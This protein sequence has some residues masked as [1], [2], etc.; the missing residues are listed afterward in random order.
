VGATVCADNVSVTD[1]LITVLLD[2]GA[3]F[4]GNERFLE[5]EVRTDT[6]LDCT[7]SAGFVVLS[8]RQALR[9]APHA[10]YALNADQLDGLNSTAFLQSI[11]VPLT[12]S[13]TSATHIIRGENASTAP[14]ASGVFG[15]STAASGITFG[16]Y[17]QTN[18]TLGLGVFGHA[19]AS[20]GLTFGGQFA[21]DS[22]SGRGVHGIAL[23]NTGNTTGVH[24]Q[25]SST[26]G[27]AVF[28]EAT[29]PSG[30]TYG[31]RFESASTAGT[32]VFGSGGLHGGW[33]E[34]NSAVGSA[35]LA[36]ATSSN[37][38]GI[39]VSGFS[40]GDEGYGVYGSGRFG[41]FGESDF[42]NGVGVYGYANAATG[43]TFG[44]RFETESTAG[45]AVYGFANAASG[46][47]YGGYLQTS[48]PDG[49][50]VFAAAVANSGA[51]YGGYF[52]TASAAGLGA[53]STNN[54]LGASFDVELSGPNG[55]INTKGFVYREYSASSPK[56]AIPV[57]YGSISAAGAINGGTGNFT[58]SHTVTGEY[59]ITI[60]G[61]TYSNNSFAVSIT[62]LQNSTPFCGTAADVGVPLRVNIWNLA[63]G[64]K[65]DLAF[66]FVVYATNPSGPG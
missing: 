62:A 24:G 47:T 1:G 8:P 26:S 2:F 7:N 23:A 20:S 14:G 58:V 49:I 46:L 19:T 35:V 29:S 11:P 37:G 59:D 63:T 66:Q 55:A 48:S 31:G 25:S 33:F 52:Q 5:I 50:G 9:I 40:G 43:A 60:S 22:T 27:R 18:S 16:V 56:A 61:E 32:G 3:Q 57:A 38:Q 15:L 44:G 65:A 21:S 54:A 30:T 53:Y 13:G 64:V 10:A 39:G 28:G 12:L 51:N 41:V 34:T 42:T 45:R 4:T 6:G 17:G 36:N